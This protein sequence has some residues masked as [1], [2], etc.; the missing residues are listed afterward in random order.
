MGRHGDEPGDIGTRKEHIPVHREK[1]SGDP[2]GGGSQGVGS[3]LLVPLWGVRDPD[4]PAGT[5]VKMFPDFPFPVSNDQDKIRD[6]GIP[7]SED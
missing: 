1:V 7:G 5:I 4:P 3:P 6:A 2:V